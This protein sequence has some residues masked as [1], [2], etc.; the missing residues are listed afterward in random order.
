MSSGIWHFFHYL[1]FTMWLGG[2]LSAMAI[3]MSMKKMDRGLWGAVVDA[4]AALYRVLIGPGAMGV[5]LSGIVMTFQTYGKMSGGGASAWIGTMQGAGVLG[6]LVTLL[7]AMPAAA[8]LTRLEP[9]GGMQAA[10]DAQR[11]RL[12]IAGS[13]GGTLGLIALLASALYQRA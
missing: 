13:I 4:Q 9:I 2:A 11:K 5:V 1:T 3:G 8:K 10:F 6:A 7:G 12:A